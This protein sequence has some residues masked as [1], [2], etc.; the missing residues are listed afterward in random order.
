MKRPGVMG[1]WILYPNWGSSKRVPH[2]SCGLMQ[3]QWGAAIPL[4]LC[5]AFCGRGGSLCRSAPPQ[6]TCM[7]RGI[8][9]IGHHR[10]WPRLLIQFALG[11]SGSIPSE[12]SAALSGKQALFVFENVNTQGTFQPRVG[13]LIQYAQ[14]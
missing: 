13:G 12:G 3:G 7:P 2:D 11:S 4:P 9:V 14:K 1:G 10:L 6:L 5:W 8:H